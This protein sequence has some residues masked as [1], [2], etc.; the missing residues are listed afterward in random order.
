MALHRGGAFRDAMLSWITDVVAKAAPPC[1]RGKSVTVFISPGVYRDYRARMQRSGALSRSW[2][3]L[4]TSQFTRHMSRQD[5]LVFAIQSINTDKIDA[6]GWGGDRFDRPFFAL[7]EAARSRP[8]WADR[9]I[10]F[11]SRDKDSRD[12]MRDLMAL[13]DHDRRVHFADSLSA[14]EELVMC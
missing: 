2:T 3:T 8:R 4:R 10:I 11:A 9:K 12:R 5:K 1:P 6:S 14:C 13:H 7:L